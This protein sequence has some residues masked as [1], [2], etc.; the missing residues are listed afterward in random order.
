M[1]IWTIRALELKRGDRVLSYGANV[2]TSV[3]TFVKKR[4]TSG[5]R[6]GMAVRFE[7]GTQWRPSSDE[8]VTVDRGAA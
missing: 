1:T 2:I 7:N 4:A 5:P 6:I 8:V 3:Q